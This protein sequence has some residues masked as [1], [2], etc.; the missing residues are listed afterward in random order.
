VLRRQAIRW[1]SSNSWSDGFKD[2]GARIV[3]PSA[4]LNHQW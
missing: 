3:R 4:R 2:K 1:E